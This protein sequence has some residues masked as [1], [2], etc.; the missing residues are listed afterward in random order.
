MVPFLILLQDHDALKVSFE[1]SERIRVQQKELIAV[2]QK[3]NH[4]MS[5][6]NSVVTMNSLSSISQRPDVDSLS[7]NKHNFTNINKNGIIPQMPFQG[8]PDW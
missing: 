7:D 5:E 3:S 2:L 6:S 4:L 8:Q 1:S